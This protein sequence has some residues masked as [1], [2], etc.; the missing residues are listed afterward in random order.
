MK[1]SCLPSNSGSKNENMWS[2]I[3]IYILSP[4]A[5]ARQWNKNDNFAPRQVWISGLYIQN[6]AEI[7]ARSIVFIFAFVNYIILSQSLPPHAVTPTLC[8]SFL[9][10]NVVSGEGEGEGEGIGM[11]SLCQAV[12]WSLPRL[13]CTHT[14]FDTY[15]FWSGARFPIGKG[16]FYTFHIVHIGSTSKQDIQSV[17]EVAFSW[18]EWPELQADH[19]F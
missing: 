16:E 3:L 17:S 7:R 1:C 12:L 13:I 9:L 4:K 6:G 15:T 10:P 2:Q 11:L 8:V 14:A 5:V 19:L 18:V